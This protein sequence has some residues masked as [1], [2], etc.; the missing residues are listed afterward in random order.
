MNLVG[1][2]FTVLIFLMCVVFGTFA[3]MVHAAHK[4]WKEVVL[5]P[6]TGLK[7]QLAKAETLNN[8]LKKEKKDLET[9]RDDER[10]K[11]R[12]RLIALEQAAKDAKSAENEMESKLQV[13]EGKSRV[14]A[15]AIQETS[16]RLGVLQ[17]AIDG[18]RN[19]IKVAVDERNRTQKNLVD[20]TDQ[21]MN[22][23][24]ER[25]R[26]EQLQRT[27]G[28]QIQ[29]LNKLVQYA[30]ITPSELAKYAP[31]GLEGDVIAVAPRR[32]R[33]IRRRR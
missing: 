19:D 29:E 15:L 2:I 21:L 27:L 16:K 1:K 20:T 22:A 30:K 6:G 13:E 7:D 10:A 26:L 11:T 24:A 18:M 32:R 33:D 28:A 3:L 4:N 23:V 12:A 5:A 31:Y 25:G 17:T 9:A 14:L 8:D